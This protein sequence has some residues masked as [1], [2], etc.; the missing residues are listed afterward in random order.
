MGTVSTLWTRRTSSLT[1]RQEMIGDAQDLL[2][3]GPL[4]Q[5]HKYNGN[6]IGLQLPLFVELRLRI[7]SRR[8]GESFGGNGT[9]PATLETGMELRVPPFIKAG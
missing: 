6:P 9:K 3:E 2:V 5:L 7:R 1:L 8:L 4:I